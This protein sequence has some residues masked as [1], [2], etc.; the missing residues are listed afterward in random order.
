MYS[1]NFSVYSAYLSLNSRDT[2]ASVGLFWSPSLPFTNSNN[3]V[4]TF[5]HALALDEV[6]GLLLSES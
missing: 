6:S 2:V 4:K 5:R 1:P 3:G